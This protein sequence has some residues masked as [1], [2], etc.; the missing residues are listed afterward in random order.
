MP[1]TPRNRNKTERSSNE[2]TEKINRSDFNPAATSK[3]V[4]PFQQQVYDLISTIPEGKVTTYQLIAKTLNCKSPRAIGQAL[5]RNPFAPQ[6]PCHRVISTSL[7]I[8]GFCGQKVGHQIER[9]VAILKK[10]GV[11]FDEKGQ[12]S[13]DQ[14]FAF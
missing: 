1:K 14:V 11:T 3:A 8:G 12:V 6:V 5:K 2:S 7:T 4:T 9:K 13:Q 10:E